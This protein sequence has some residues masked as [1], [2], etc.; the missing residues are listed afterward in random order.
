MLLLQALYSIQIAGKAAFWIHEADQKYFLH[1]YISLSS[2]DIQ[3]VY[4][5]A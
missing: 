2:R 1:D 4:T 5:V 3:F